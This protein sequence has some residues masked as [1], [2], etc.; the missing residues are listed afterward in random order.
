MKFV[1]HYQSWI[2][3]LLQINNSQNE[4]KCSQYMHETL[5]GFL[6]ENVYRKFHL[7]I[8]FDEHLEI[9]K[10]EEYMVHELLM[11][12]VNNDSEIC[13]IYNVLNTSLNGYFSMKQCND[14]VVRKWIRLN[15]IMQ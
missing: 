2:D 9:L 6:S 13:S 5:N 4:Y 15:K 14:Q 8:R 1:Q 10:D 3:L 11:K 7:K 12:K